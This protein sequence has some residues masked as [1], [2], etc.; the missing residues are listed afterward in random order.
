M[1]KVTCPKCDN[2][3][4]TLDIKET[5]IKTTKLKWNYTKRRYINNGVKKEGITEM[6]VYCKKCNAKIRV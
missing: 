6:W 5:D 3:I 4:V 1:N 2:L